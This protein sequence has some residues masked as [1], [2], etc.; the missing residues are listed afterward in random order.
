MKARTV[1]GRGEKTLPSDLGSI[2]RLGREKY[3]MCEDKI[4]QLQKLSYS[5]SK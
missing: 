4:L 5:N 2:F 1:V 3:I